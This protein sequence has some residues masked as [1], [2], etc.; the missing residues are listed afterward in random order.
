MFLLQKEKILHEF[1][2]FNV[3]K[4]IVVKCLPLQNVDAER[5]RQKGGS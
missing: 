5:G 3:M 4:I 1:Y 2:C